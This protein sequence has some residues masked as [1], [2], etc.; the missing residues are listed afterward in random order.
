ME[1]K[2]LKKVEFKVADL[3]I[4]ISSVVVGENDDGGLGIFE[5]EKTELFMNG[6]WFRITTSPKFQEFLVSS[7]YDFIDIDKFDTPENTE[8]VCTV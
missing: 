2:T 4:R 1:I 3:P 6:Y 7:A 8:S 5:W